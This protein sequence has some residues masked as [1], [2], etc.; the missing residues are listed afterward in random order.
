MGHGTQVRGYHGKAGRLPLEAPLHIDKHVPDQVAGIDA[1]IMKAVILGKI[2]QF[3]G[4]K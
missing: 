2:G 3:P 1:V 4:I